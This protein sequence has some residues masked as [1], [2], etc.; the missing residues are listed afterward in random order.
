MQEFIK[1]FNDGG[2]FMYP[3]LILAIIGSIIIVERIYMIIFVYY[4]SGAVLMQKIQRLILDN[5]LD[6]AVKVCNS[7]KHAAIYQIFKAAL[8]TADRP[9]EEIQDH[10][11]V[12]NLALIPKLQDRMP[13]L[14]TIANVA[15]LLGLLGT[16]AGLIQTFQSIGAVEESQKQLMLA[17][18]ISTAMNTTAFGL[19]VAVPCSLVYGFLY[20]KINTVID[21]VEHY[22]GRL[23]LLLRT[24]GQYFDYAKKKE[25]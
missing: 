6:E 20:N 12:A 25:E 1:F 8:V 19:I 2:F 9:Y 5:N 4:A 18:G 11:Q 3:I 13:Y 15:T 23:L 7:K 21:E 17:A 22:S 24:G 10:V 16:I 14:S